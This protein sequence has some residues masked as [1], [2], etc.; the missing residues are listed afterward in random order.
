MKLRKNCNV[1]SHVYQT[2]V[3]VEVT[4]KFLIH[5]TSH[6][7]SLGVTVFD[8]PIG[9]DIGLHEQ[10]KAKVSYGMLLHC[11]P[12]QVEPAYIE[13]GNG[14]AAM[15]VSQVNLFELG[16]IKLGPVQISSLD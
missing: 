5:P 10:R 7:N 3:Y 15:Q 1:G 14:A 12:G 11:K 4:L 2:D 8:N 13:C 16:P 9:C 6:P